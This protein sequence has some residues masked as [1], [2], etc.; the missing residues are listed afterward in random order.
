MGEIRDP[1]SSSGGEMEEIGE[2]DLPV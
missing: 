2:Y 1:E